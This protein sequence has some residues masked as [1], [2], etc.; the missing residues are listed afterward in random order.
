MAKQTNQMCVGTYLTTRL[1]QLGVNHL[2][3]VPG[4]YTSDFL[5][6]V[7]TQSKLTRIGNCNELNAGYAADGYARANGLGAV[8]ITTG[9]GAFSVLNAIGGAYVE[10]SPVV[11]IIGTLSNTKLLDETNAGELFHHQV[12]KT[13][14]N[15]T[16]F[17]QVTVAF[18]R[19]RNPLSAPAQI[20]A[21]LTACISHSRPAAIEIME[22]CYYMPCATPSGFLTPTPSYE[23]YDTLQKIAP[24][25]KYAAQIVAAIQGAANQ[26][27]NLLVASKKPMLWVGKEIATDSLSEY[28]LK[29]QKLIKA[30]FVSSLLGKSSVAETHA[31][32]AGMHDG[33]FTQPTTQ[34]LLNDCDCLIGLGVWN[35][36]LN[37]F[38]PKPNPEAGNPSTVFASRNMVK[39]G[40]DLYVQV[41]LQNLVIALMEIIQSKGYK[42]VWQK[43]PGA[44]P[45]PPAP[46]SSAVIT[47]DYFF[48]VL[49]NYLT[50]SHLLVSEIGLSTFGGS[51][52][53]SIKRQDGYIG[54][55]IWASIGW[56]VPAGLGA[57][58]TK[59]TRAIVVVGDGAF[60]LTC[61]EISTMVQQKRNTVI[62]VL[63]NK[64]YAV[65]QIL[66]NAA[67]FT[68]GSNAP[69]EAANIL[70]EWDYVS[71]MNAFSNNNSKAAMS[72]NVNTVQDLQNVLSQ[73]NKTPNAVWLVNINLNER[74]YPAAWGPFVPPPAQAKTGIKKSTKIKK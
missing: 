68:K 29:L 49:S 54:Q 71:L 56:S 28:F 52:Y 23:S 74:D 8:A 25:N 32:Y 2:F 5:E 45:L 9:V 21:V 44:P 12:N 38:S 42:P 63:N 7:D 48:D 36:D 24:T 41:S 61:Q 11:L 60:K 66:L 65:E 73:I 6:I 27:Y 31:W 3:S 64:V 34:D 59:D 69:F 26:V 1:Q 46:A 47:Y 72:A 33:I 4:D 67:P 15:K 14:F 70:Q 20:D 58:F 17:G 51:S 39:V 19:I 50:P 22:D 16:V 10:K 30:P 40:E 13:D 18:E 62:F 35:T 57:S 43:P 55:N 53:L 37:E